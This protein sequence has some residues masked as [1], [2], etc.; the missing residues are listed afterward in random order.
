MPKAKIIIEF[1]YEIDPNNYPENYSVDD[2]MQSDIESM[3]EG[4]LEVQEF[5]FEHGWKITG[6]IVKEEEN[7]A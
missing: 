5:G 4:N 1:E 2:M 7:N 6:E 3:Q